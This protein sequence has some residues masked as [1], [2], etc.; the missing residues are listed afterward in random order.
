MQA[1]RYAQ[2][3]ET[4]PN[5][6]GTRSAD[7]YSYSERGESLKHV[8]MFPATHAQKFHLPIHSAVLAWQTLR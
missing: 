6:T 8:F 1:I 7:W 4:S 5:T 2:C 3:R